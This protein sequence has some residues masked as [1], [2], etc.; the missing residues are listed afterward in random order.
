VGGE[1]HRSGEATDM[2]RRLGALAEWT[3]HRYPSFGQVTHSWSGQVMEPVDYLPFSG[4]NPGNKRTYVH[5]GDSGQG[6]TNGVAGALTIAP[7][8][9]GEDSRFAEILAPNRKPHSLHS[10]K[11][12]AE[13]VG[14]AAKNLAEHLGPGEIAS[15]DEL[16]PNEGGTMREGLS[17][18]AVFKGADGEVIRRS[19]VC[20]H[21][22]CIVHWNTFE[23]CWDCPCHGSQFAP[24]GQVLNGPAVKPLAQAD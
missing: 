19:A 20:T 23:K 2:D 8:I 18:I 5:T 4:L 7:L 13:G 10:L 1:D 22:G 16:S 24:D 14:G 3:R 15:A 6:I 9:L 17:K 11:E 12:F 21:V